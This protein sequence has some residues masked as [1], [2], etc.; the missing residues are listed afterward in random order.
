LHK[1]KRPGGVH[2]YDTLLS[3]TDEFGTWLFAP[4]GA[5]WQ[6]PHDSGRLPFDVLVLL[7]PARPYVAWWCNDPHGRRLE[8]D[9]CLPPEPVTDGWSFVDLELDVI[10]HE[11]TGRTEVVD[12][13]EF[14]AARRAGLIDPAA[15]RLAL[16]TARDVQARA[17]DR[18]EPLGSAGWR[19]LAPL[20][21]NHG[22][23]PTH[24]N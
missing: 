1:I 21:R 6:A 22:V 16:A 2:R 9:V 10:R 13:D 20:R 15:A 14:R 17:R 11:D 23:D 24:E 4:Q 8:I 5:A 18:V 7:A 3:G 12:H 19:N